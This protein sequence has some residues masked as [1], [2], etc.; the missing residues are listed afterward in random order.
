LRLN[1]SDHN[2]TI[3]RLGNSLADSIRSLGFSLCANDASLSLL[4]R[5]LDD[6]PRSLGLLL[7]NLLV[8][9]GLGELL[10]ERQVCDGDV[11]EGDVELCGAAEEVG[12]YPVRDGF[13]LCDELGGVELSYDGFEDF[14]SDRGEDTLVVVLA[15]VLCRVLV[16][17]SFGL[18]VIFSVSP[19]RSLVAP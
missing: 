3:T 6:E 14:V 12:S 5:L 8:L 11:F 4:L 9:D 1:P 16:T 17:G 15:E 2:Q 13:S 18:D 19:G 7:R 10:A